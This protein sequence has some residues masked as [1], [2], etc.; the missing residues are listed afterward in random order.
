M[1]R[2]QLCLTLLT[3]LPLALSQPAHAQAPGKKDT[4]VKAARGR[5]DRHG[6]P[7]PEG[8]LARLGTIRLRHPGLI[9][10]VSLSPNGKLVASAGG[11]AVRLWD[12]ASGK[13]IREHLLK[14]GARC[15]A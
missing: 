4:S 2:S 3:C 12:V 10:S 8:A 13:L 6:D 15:V 1:S 14:G 7:L 5:T 9:Q 11:K